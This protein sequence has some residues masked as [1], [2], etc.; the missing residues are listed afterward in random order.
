[1]RLRVSV[2]RSNKYIYA[3]IIDDKEGKTKASA[4]DK[5]SNAFQVGLNLAKQALKKNIAEVTFDRGKFLY[6]GR[7]KEL[8]RGAR[9]GG[10]KF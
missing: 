4:F 8:A 3:Q 7:V 2:F 10:L 5:K 9:E 6:H 1:M